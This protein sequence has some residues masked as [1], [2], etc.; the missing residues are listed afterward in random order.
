M[1][2]EAVASG[3][4]C[5]QIVVCTADLSSPGNSF[6]FSVLPT[7]PLQIRNFGGSGYKMCIDS[8][9]KRGD[10]HK[11]VGLYPCHNQGG[12][13][14]IVMRLLSLLMPERDH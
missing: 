3:E 1:P 4:V 9:A 14:V 13:Q 8:A 5:A 11:P 10:M 7:H 12:N 6:I 2:G